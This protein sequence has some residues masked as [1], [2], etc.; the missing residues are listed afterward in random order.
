MIDV[1]F[2]EQR[3]HRIKVYATQNGARNLIELC[4]T[5][6]LQVLQIYSYITYFKP[7]LLLLDEPD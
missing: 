7:K 2:D 4:G 6:L 1:E 5:G 3:D